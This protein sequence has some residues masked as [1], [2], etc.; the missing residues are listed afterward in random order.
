MDYLFLKG[1]SSILGRFF[2]A[3]YLKNEMNKRTLMNIKG[4]LVPD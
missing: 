3:E 2:Y 4:K 1:N